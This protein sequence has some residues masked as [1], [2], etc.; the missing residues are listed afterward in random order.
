MKK[1][2]LREI[3]R[4]EIFS[5]KETKVKESL[6]ISFASDWKNV[7]GIFKNIIKGHPDKSEVETGVKTAMQIIGLDAKSFNGITKS[8]GG[9]EITLDYK[10][11]LLGNNEQ[12]RFDSL[13]K[14]ELEKK[15]Y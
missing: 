9:F 1:S 3:I 7:K 10:Y 2:V 5:L 6:N 8:G 14:K 11:A 12:K 15:H 13:I 4:Q